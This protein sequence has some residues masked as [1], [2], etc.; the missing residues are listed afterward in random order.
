AGRDPTVV[1]GATPL[2]R[3]GGGFEGSGGRNGRGDVAVIEACEYRENFLYLKPHTALFWTSSPIISTSSALSSPCYPPARAV[4]RTAPTMACSWS[5]TTVRELAKSSARQAAESP[6]S[7]WRE[8]R[9]GAP[10]ICNRREVVTT[11]TLCAA[12]GG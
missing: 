1:C 10:P 2:C 8:V 6:P 11:S 7:V 4:R 3:E 9:N 12:D 5:P